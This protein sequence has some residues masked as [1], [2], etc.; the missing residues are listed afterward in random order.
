MKELRPEALA[1]VE[2]FGY[3]DN[4]VTSAIGQSDG[5]VYQRLLDWAQNKNQVNQEPAKSEIKKVMKDTL[6]QMKPRL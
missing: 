2:A 4:T 1:L 5:K 3:D 6:A